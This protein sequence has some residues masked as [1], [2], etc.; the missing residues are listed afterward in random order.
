[1]LSLQELSDRIEIQDLLVRYSHAVDTR[2]WKLFAE[3]F[4]ED[5][6]VDYTAFGG[7]CGTV[8]E[9]TAFL[10]SVLPMFT[11]TQHLVANSAVVLEGDR[12]T[13][14][15]MCHNPMALPGAE[16]AAGLLLCGLWY[17]DELVRTP[18]GWR[19]RRRSEDKAYSIALA[20][21]AG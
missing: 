2:E 3:C 10:A 12:A 16:G 15:T 5:A 14:R 9:V 13:A 4:T 8:A 19:L 11:A 7:P 18:D 20:P 6:V 17:V 1:M 21:P